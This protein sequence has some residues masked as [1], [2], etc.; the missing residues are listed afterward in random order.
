MT[1]ARDYFIHQSSY[2]DGN[3]QIGEGTKIWH[4]CHIM[5]G[6][7]IGAH[8][9]IGQNV[10]IG[11]D[12]AIGNRCKLQNNVSVYKGVTLE[13]DVF[14]GPSCV[15]TNVYNPRAFI[16]RKHEFRQTLVKKG[17]TIGANAT[18]IC[19]ITIGSYAMIGAGAVVRDDVADYGLVLGVPAR[20]AG[21]V[22]QCGVTLK[23]MTLR[24]NGSCG[25]CGNRYLLREGK[26][27]IA[28]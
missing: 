16:E 7:S 4:F 13:D 25:Y 6:S 2:A 24:G 21:W 18:I 3:V 9:S 10:L 28:G 22:C 1:D 23:D 26:L 5:D 17:A 20:Q 14:C 12:V 15:F 11:P 27:E 8:C 19:G